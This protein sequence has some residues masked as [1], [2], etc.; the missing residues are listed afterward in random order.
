[1]RED[2]GFSLA[3]VVVALFVILI[4][5]TALLAAL[6][7]SIKAVKSSSERSEAAQLASE[8]LEALQAIS[9]ED[10]LGFYATDPDFRADNEGE[11]TKVLTG[12]RAVPCPTGELTAV[13]PE[14]TPACPVVTRR[15]GNVA[16]TVRTDITLT[17]DASGV[18]VPAPTPS[19]SL[20]YY[21]VHLR[22]QVDWTNAGG[23]RTTVLDAL[24]SPTPDEL[25][26]VAAA[27]A[28]PSASASPAASPGSLTGTLDLDPASQVL[29]SGSTTTQ[30]VVA[31]LS[32]TA[33]PGGVS[34][35]WV[36]GA[37]SGTLSWTP[38]ATRLVWTARISAGTLMEPGTLTVTAVATSGAS[39]VSFTETA[40]V[41]SVATPPVSILQPTVSPSLCRRAHS[42]DNQWKLLRDSTVQVE[43]VGV[44][45]GDTVSVGW[46]N[47]N[48]A[49][50]PAQFVGIGPNGGGLFSYAIPTGTQFLGSSTTVTV[51]ALRPSDPQPASEGFSFPV[52]AASTATSC[53]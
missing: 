16:Y 51:A 22:V 23:D 24:R 27:A 38:D 19:S 41:S 40:T 14:P 3:E 46:T 11:T 21:Y 37:R 7:T 13:D 6:G 36:N 8:R 34:G 2:R 4:V 30:Q 31:E 39:S 9:F 45:S 25:T 35:S 17:D 47:P 44:G 50:R 33:A 5:M 12:T 53:T 26:P 15:I 52:Q 10:E 18:P 28:T 48:V 29:S 32:T 20:S 1:M 42:N 43:I 49:D